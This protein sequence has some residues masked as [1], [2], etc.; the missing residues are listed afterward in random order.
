MEYLK[1]KDVADILSGYAFDSKMFTNNQLDVIPLIR[2]RDVKRGYTE[3]YYKGIYDDKYIIT[4]GTLLIGMDGEFNIGKWNSANALLNQRVCK[5][6]GRKGKAT[7]RYLFYYLNSELKQIEDRTSFVTVK[8]LS[9]KDIYEI[10]FPKINIASQNNIADILDTAQSHI[11][12][13][14]QQIEAC[15]ELIKSR[16]VEM[17]GVV[18]TNSKNFPIITLDEICIKITDG[19]HGGCEVEDGS[20]YYYVGAREIHNG[21]IHYDTAPEITYRD[22]EKDYR[23]SNIEN[24]D[25]VIVNTGATIGKT[26]IANSLS[27][28]KTLLQKSVALLK[29][30]QDIALP[31]F[32]QYCY[33]TNPKMYKVDSASAQPN[34]LI[35]KIKKTSCYLPPLD[36]QS[37]FILFVQQVDKLKFSLQKS[38]SEMEDNFNV[39]MQQAFKGEIFSGD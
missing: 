36:M 5:I 1:I 7:D 2:I 12:K 38:L 3:S 17:F 9:V 25:F 22:F 16:F 37:E 23:R 31:K 30:K 14:K 4:K 33:I 24:G 8:H 39:L 15:D 11:D 27:T 29:V 10:S 34:L 26:A 35:S 18:D 13:R 20:G 19:K 32:L 6:S 28:E 21:E